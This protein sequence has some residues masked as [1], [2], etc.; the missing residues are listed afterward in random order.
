MMN[1]LKR[2]FRK[3]PLPDLRLR[4]MMYLIRHRRLRFIRDDN[5]YEVNQQLTDLLL[6]DELIF[7][8]DCDGVEEEFVKRHKLVAQQLEELRN[9]RSEIKEVYRELDSVKE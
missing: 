7:L 8:R 5:L 2:W 1:F 9:L 3:Q 4:L 6:G